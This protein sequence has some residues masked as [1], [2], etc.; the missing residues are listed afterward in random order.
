MKRIILLTILTL[1]FSFALFAQDKIDTSTKDSAKLLAQFN[2]YESEWY[3]FTM[4]HIGDELRNSSS[5][6]GLIRIRNDKNIERR[7]SQLK[8][9]L[10]I[11]KMDLTRITFIM[12]KEQENDTDVLVMQKCSEMPKCENCIVIRAEDIDKITKLFSPKVIK[13][14]KIKK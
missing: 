11:Y 4:V 12:V 6:T 13:N 5:T 3:K 14:K 2:D 8:K 1:S 10:L 9:G 7:L